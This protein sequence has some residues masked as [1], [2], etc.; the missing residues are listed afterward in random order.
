MEKACLSYT[1]Q[2]LAYL[3]QTKGLL[4]LHR[5]KACLSYTDQKLAYLTQTKGFI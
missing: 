4:I 3:T 2:S 5:P 1:D